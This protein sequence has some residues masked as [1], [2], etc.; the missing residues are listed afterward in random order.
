MGC[1]A[2]P[3]ERGEACLTAPQLRLVRGDGVPGVA[4]AEEE[5]V[6]V[7]LGYGVT[8][9]TGGGNRGG[10]RRGLGIEESFH[11][12]KIGFDGGAVRASASVVQQ[13]E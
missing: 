8:D 4:I 12:T 7:A 11:G 3:S 10:E 1:S 6:T 9:V 5:G 2:A 13:T